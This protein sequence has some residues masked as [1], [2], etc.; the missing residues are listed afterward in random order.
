[1]IL[2]VSIIK[3]HTRTRVTYG[4]TSEFCGDGEAT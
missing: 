2:L 1:M 3:I 4:G